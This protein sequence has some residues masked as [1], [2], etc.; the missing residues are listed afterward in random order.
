MVIDSTL[1]HKSKNMKQVMPFLF[2]SMSFYVNAQSIIKG[3]VIDDQNLAIIGAN[4]YIA[5]SY[6]GT[7]TDVEGNF[8][9]STEETGVQTLIVSFL[10]YE[11]YTKSGDI[12]SFNNLSIKLK[13]SVLSLD[14]VVIT[15]GSFEG[16]EK[17]RVSVLKPLDIVTTA[18]TAGNIIGALNTLPGTQTVGEDGRLFVRGGEASETQTYVDGMRVGQPYGAAANNTP[19]RSRFSPF[20]FSGVSFSTGGY[21]AEYGEALSSVLSMNTIAEPSQNQ[22]EISIMSVGLGLSKTQKWKNQSISLNLSYLNLGVYQKLVPQKL[23]WNKPIT[24]SGGEVVYRFKL[25]NGLL[26]AYGAYDISKLDINNEDINHTNKIRFSLKNTNAYGNLNYKGTLGSEY[27]IHTGISYGKGRNDINVDVDQ[28]NNMENSLHA[29]MKLTRVYSEKI[30]LSGGLDYYLTDFDEK[31]TESFTT[32]YPLH[33]AN[34]IGA[35]Y[36][37]SDIFINK[38]LAFKVGARASINDLLR[39]YHLNPRVSMAYKFAKTGQFSLAFGDFSQ[40]PNNDVIKFSPSVESERAKHYILNYQ[41]KKEGRLFRSEAYFKNYTNLIKYNTIQPQYNSNYDNNGV[42][43]AKGL[44]IFWRDGKT[45]KETDYWISYSF[46]DSKRDYQNFENKATPSFIATH[47]FSLVTKHWIEKL[48]SQLG[49]SYSIN[50]GRPYHNP[51]E[52][53][54]M[55]GK[56]KAYQNLSFNWAYL[57]SKQKIF[58][59]SIS[60]I[61]GTDNVFGYQYANKPNSVGVYDRKAI[62]Q[63]ADRF[64]FFGFFWTISDDNKSNMLDNL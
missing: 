6:D 21:S 60:N 22:T 7:V 23:D 4:I 20:L 25:K 30:S 63:P 13:E 35:A 44:D 38:N 36:L 12:S 8:Q 40:M 9:F 31:Y 32:E 33:Y 62:G 43:Y 52:E 49:F 1:Y 29:K 3:R 64:I 11:T 15:A 48:T 28:V 47:T 56:T 50:S 39:E 59:F 41:Y 24:S 53:E 17:A 27:L 61:M 19:T 5:G 26:R 18:G 34:H 46:I 10:S 51:N 57:M 42:G 2:L 54:F 58:Y 55:N 37:E 16:G 45:F 14:A